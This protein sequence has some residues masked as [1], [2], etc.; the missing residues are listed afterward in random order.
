MLLSFCAFAET[1]VSIE[2]KK[3]IEAKSKQAKQQIHKLKLLEKIET[4]KLYKNQ[5]KLEYTQYSLQKNQKEYTSKQ[6]EYKNLQRK[7]DD[8]LYENREH[9][10]YTQ[11]RIVQIY[12][13]KRV[14]YIDFLINATDINSFLD[15]LYFENM[16]ISYDKKK[17]QE[18]QVYAK[19][20]YNLRTRLE[21]Q[22]KSLE[23]SI[24]TINRQQ[25]DIQDAIQKNEQLI[26]KLKTDRAT[27]EKAEKDLAKQS[28][29]I[30]QL[31]NQ[32]EKKKQKEGVKAPVVTS[33]FIKPVQGYKITSE[34][35]WRVHPIF[36]RRKY[37]SGV[38]LAVSYGTPIKAANSG[39]VIFVGWYSGYG[40]VVII[41]HG[42]INGSSIQTLYA[43]MSQTSIRQG[44]T[45]QKGAIIGKVGTTGYSTGPH[46]HFEVRQK[47]SPVNPHGYV[48][49]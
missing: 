23:S 36:K 39:R 30:A 15:R 1:S 10:N 19:K 41:D 16:V 12:K 48:K 9:L 40:K 13:H 25:V 2:D 7:L 3:E 20:M 49:L 21:A 43:H 45:V 33:G 32:E 18:A 29:A 31:I 4:N 47:G 35:G 27:W 44:A 11:K 42:T 24:A 46:V 14:S 6:N 8:L 37:H 17:L 22:K 28:K 26:E 34:F 5:Q 38:D